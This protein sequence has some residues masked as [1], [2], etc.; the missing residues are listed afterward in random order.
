MFLFLKKP[1]SKVYYWIA[2]LT[3]LP[4]L[5]SIAA[6]VVY[7]VFPELL[8]DLGFSL[9]MFGMF[10]FQSVLPLI[11]L[12]LIMKKHPL[13]LVFSIFCWITFAVRNVMILFVSLQ[14]AIP[15]GIETLVFSAIGILIALV[16]IGYI[17]WI[18]RKEHITPTPAEAVLHQ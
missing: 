14:T 15:T 16:M 6:P 1:L 13:G 10:I 11:G 5:Q 2:F 18:L 3:A 9:T 7:I 12:F 4:A 8:F 17:V